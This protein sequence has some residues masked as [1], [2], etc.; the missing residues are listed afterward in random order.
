MQLT[1]KFGCLVA[2]DKWN[3]IIKKIRYKLY[4]SKMIKPNFKAEMNVTT[5]IVYKNG[6]A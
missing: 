2:Y 6:Q 1:R 3:K 5:V 4:P